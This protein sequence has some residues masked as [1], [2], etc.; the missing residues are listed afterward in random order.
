MDEAG[1]TDGAAAASPAGAR[2]QAGASCTGYWRR[3]RSPG[4]GVEAKL[5]TLHDYQR[6]RGLCIRCGEKWSRDHRCPEAIQLQVLQEVWDLCHAE[7]SKE[8]SPAQDDDNPQ[9]F[10]MISAAAVSDRPSNN[11]MQFMGTIQGHP[12]K[13]LLD[14]SSS[15]MFISSTIAAQLEGSSVCTQPIKVMVANGSWSVLLNF[16]NCSGLLSSVCLYLQLKCFHFLSLI[17]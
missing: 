17:S 10:L 8:D 14:S 2:G 7:G 9:V 12:V 4:H 13:I 1:A 5:A 15:H 6:A 3:R 16:S 11:T